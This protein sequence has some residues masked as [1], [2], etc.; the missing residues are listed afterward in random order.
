[1]SFEVPYQ[2]RYATF[3]FFAEII[4]AIYWI[5]ILSYTSVKNHEALLSVLLFGLH[6]AGLIALCDLLDSVAK[7]KNVM[8][9][10]ANDFLRRN[11]RHTMGG[12]RQFKIK[13]LSKG[14]EG[15][16]SNDEQGKD[17]PFI[18]K[19]DSDIAEGWTHYPVSY[20]VALFVAMI[21]DLFSF[22]EVILN[23]THHKSDFVLF[24]LHA[25]LFGIGLCL[26]LL[27]IF[28][29]FFCYFKTTINKKEDGG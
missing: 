20:G 6:Y 2:S 25:S 18:E 15:T 19:N 22:V 9:D 23:Y 17:V 12:K 14:S 7:R 27:S 3:V 4:L 28:W 11:K 8:I 16:F 1:M 13:V 26:T 24:S 5:A 21:S 29:S 10:Y